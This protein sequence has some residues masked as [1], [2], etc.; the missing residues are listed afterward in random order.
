MSVSLIFY[1]G[2]PDSFDLAKATILWLFII[3]TAALLVANFQRVWFRDLRVTVG[4]GIVCLTAI[5]TASSESPLLSTYG[6]YQRYSGFAT[7]LACF[8]LYLVVSLLLQRD[9]LSLI[10]GALAVSNFVCASYVVLQ[11]VG[12]DPWGWNA[13]GQEV[14]A[15]GTI[16]NINTA[17]GFLSISSMSFVWFLL[18]PVSKT[19][20][21]LFTIGLVFCGGAI[22]ATQSFQGPITAFV[23]FLAAMFLSKNLINVSDRI[24]LRGSAV[25]MVGFAFVLRPDLS[26][27]A[28]PAAVALG[29][30]NVAD[31][32]GLSLLAKRRVPDLSRHAKRILLLAVAGLLGVLSWTPIL[33]QVRSGMRERTAFYSSAVKLWGENPW[34]GRGI[35]TF[36]R[37]YSSERP[38]W[39]AIELERNRTSS[40]HSIPI[41][42]LYAGGLILA[43]AVLSWIVVHLLLALKTRSPGRHLSLEVTI[44][45]WML[46]SC[47]VQ[48]SVSVE[49]VS[50]LLLYFLV[51]ALLANLSRSRFQL[52]RPS[53]GRASA[54]FAV[55]V[56]GAL[57]LPTLTT[58]F[59]A[60]RKYLNATQLSYVEG[61]F[62]K[63]L[64]TV[65]RAADMVPWN[66]QMK[67]R[68]L[69]MAQD[70][71]VSL[72]Y[73]DFGYDAAVQS[74]C[75]PTMAVG[76]SNL[77]A[78]SGDFS[79]AI[80]LGLCAIKAD[81]H[82]PN[83]KKDVSS[84]FEAMATAA[85]TDGKPEVAQAIRETLV[86]AV[87][88]DN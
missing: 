25:L 2:I 56:V 38:A 54:M 15:F 80:E 52:P 86:E 83:V 31:L 81:P 13:P 64:E 62:E 41:S 1:R 67:A 14:Q 3:P 22:G 82:A 26:W 72:R 17:S 77:L 19:R 35:E 4:L 23:V 11:A 68:V 57:L 78:Q 79:R 75:L 28:L 69:D 84:I 30:I 20:R 61:D 53:R 43:V 33:N 59:R 88:I 24:V 71:G 12:F 39:H 9:Q 36:G 37:Y 21:S 27:V 85:E 73:A 87:L 29:A 50:L 5:R 55:L 63:G 8:L 74:Q 48:S 7:L 70:F 42:L 76:V 60:D 46:A 65:E 45:L 44:G 18:K 66:T 32:S 6:Q 49:H 16:G 47:V 51:L 40:V 34:W 58:Q 10:F